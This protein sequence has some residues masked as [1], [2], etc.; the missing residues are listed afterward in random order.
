MNTVSAWATAG[1]TGPLVMG[2]GGSCRLPR[3]EHAAVSLDGLVRELEEG[4]AIEAVGVAVDV[5]GVLRRGQ[6]IE[7]GVLK[8]HLE[9]D[10]EGVRI[11]D[12]VKLPVDVH[13]VDALLS[14]HLVQRGPR[15]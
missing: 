3:D 9:S 15:G 4:R 2:P 13:G 10:H 11:R 8:W 5:H 6:A 1:S 7:L 14:H 12:A